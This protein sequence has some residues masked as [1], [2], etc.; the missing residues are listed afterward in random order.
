MTAPGFRLARATIRDIDVLTRCRL[1]LFRELQG[2]PAPAVAAGFEVRCREALRD[3][4]AGDTLVAWV[5]QPAGGG[6]PIGSLILLLYP[7]LP[8]LANLRTRE[9]YLINVYTRPDWRGRGVGGSLMDAALAHARRLGL[10]RIR[11]HAS[12]LGR[13]L[14]SHYAFHGREDE[15]ELDL[16]GP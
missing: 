4:F 3:G 8:S 9:G 6:E 1:D 2:E 15:M 12:P 7:R 14:Y 16:S 13:R 11:L 10:A 5:A